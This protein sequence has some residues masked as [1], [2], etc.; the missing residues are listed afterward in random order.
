[1]VHRV[2]IYLMLFN[3]IL[4]VFAYAFIDIAGSDAA[5]DTL[6]FIT[7]DELT[8]AGIFLQTQER[9]ELQY[10]AANPIEFN[11]SN[12]EVR[13]WWRDGG[14]LR[15]SNIMVYKRS[16]A[17]VLGTWF[18][19]D[20]LNVVIDG[21]THE[22]LVN[23]VRNETIINGYNE[24]YNWTQASVPQKGIELFFT[25]EAAGGNMT[26]A[27]YDDGLVN[28]TLGTTVDFEDMDASAFIDW[29]WGLLTTDSVYGLPVYIKWVFQIQ[30]VLLIFTAVIIGRELT[31]V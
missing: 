23:Y 12:S 9:F 22:F 13:V 6:E 4:P 7:K 18:F 28:V 15:E 29:Y 30:L 3:L 1:M 16:V 8:Q 24:A 11:A 17:D 10:D 2:A 31:R 21:T 26:Q 14:F 25:C 5:G 20:R 27:I 19:V